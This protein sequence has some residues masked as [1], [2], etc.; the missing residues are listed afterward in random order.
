VSFQSGEARTLGS[1]TLQ[2]SQPFPGILNLM[3]TRISIFPELEEFS[4][5]LYG[6]GFPIILVDFS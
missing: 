3:D 1:L 2:P 5:M 4:I 6:F